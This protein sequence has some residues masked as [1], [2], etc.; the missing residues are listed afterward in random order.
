M[1]YGALL[2]RD[3]GHVV[4]MLLSDPPNKAVAATPEAVVDILRHRLQTTGH[5][6]PIEIEVKWDRM[7]KLL[8]ILPTIPRRWK[9]A[10][11]HI[12]AAT[13][14]GSGS[15]ENDRFR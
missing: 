6:E 8:G 5:G 2:T 4:G 15:T 7:A 1:K 12:I 9:S 3:N 13:R 14:S 11:R 10:G